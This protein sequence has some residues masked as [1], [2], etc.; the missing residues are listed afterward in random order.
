MGLRRMSDRELKPGVRHLAILML[1]LALVGLADASYLTA[2]HWLGQLPA[3]DL[4]GC[5]SVLTS[6]YATVGPVPVAFIGSV[7]YLILGLTLVSYL[8]TGREERLRL[9]ARFT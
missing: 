1:G 5:E 2:N 3:C 4:S 6:S 8:E 9:T 7:Y